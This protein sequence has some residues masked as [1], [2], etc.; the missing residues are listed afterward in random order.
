MVRPGLGSGSFSCSGQA[1]GRI[2]LEGFDRPGG[3][4]S[5]HSARGLEVRVWCQLPNAVGRRAA[6][7]RPWTTRRESRGGLP[8]A[9]DRGEPAEGIAR[10]GTS[11]HLFGRPGLSPGRGPPG[12]KVLPALRQNRD[13]PTSRRS[14]AR[15]LRPPNTTLCVGAAGGGRRNSAIR[16]SGWASNITTVREA[17][18]GAR[19]WNRTSTGF[20][21]PDP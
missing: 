17:N 10:R 9:C 4:A 21:P 13:P 6:E 19:D 1:R 2:P 12:P 20:T 18:G 16:V 15:S 11:P 8:R 14:S 7:G 3:R 5:A